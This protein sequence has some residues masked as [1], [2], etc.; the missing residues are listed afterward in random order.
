M[1]T[2]N[3]KDV[4]FVRRSGNRSMIAASKAHKTGWKFIHNS[5]GGMSSWTGPV[6]K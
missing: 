4:V 3:D 2:P 5:R 1:D 6:A